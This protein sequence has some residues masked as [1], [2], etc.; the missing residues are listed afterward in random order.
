MKFPINMESHKKCSKHFQTTNQI[1]NDLVHSK[2]WPPLNHQVGCHI[3]WKILQV[4]RQNRAARPW[5]NLQTK[6]GPTVDLPWISHRIHVCYIYIYGNMDPIKINPSHVRINIPAPW[7]RHGYLVDFNPTLTWFQQ[8]YPPGGSKKTAIQRD[9][10]LFREIYREQKTEKNSEIIDCNFFFPM[11][12]PL[13]LFKSPWN[14]WRFRHG[15]ITA[16]SRCFFG[17]PTV[18]HSH[19]AGQTEIRNPWGVVFFF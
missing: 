16:K 5:S 12:S 18:G 2:D 3:P 1:R 15:K 9:P 6:C 10:R 14:S 17:I 19:H 8:E 4:K 11:K 13:K 7:I